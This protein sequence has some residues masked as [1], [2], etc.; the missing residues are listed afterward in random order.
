MSCT[1]VLLQSIEMARLPH[2]TLKATAKMSDEV[3]RQDV[4]NLLAWANPV[5]RST[6]NK[7]L[8]QYPVKQIKRSCT[9]ECSS[10]DKSQRS[11]SNPYFAQ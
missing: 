5:S 6:N 11:L 2:R 3:V 8:G 9:S 7:D 4:M 10:L 1:K